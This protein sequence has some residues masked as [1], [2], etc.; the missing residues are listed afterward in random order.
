MSVSAPVGRL[1]DAPWPG[2]FLLKESARLPSKTKIIRESLDA[3]RPFA[4]PYRNSVT[5]QPASINISKTTSFRNVA[6]NFWNVAAAIVWTIALVVL[7][8]RPLLLSQ[9]GTSFDTYGLAGSHWLHGEDLYTH[10]MGFVYS[11]LVAAFFAP[12]AFFPSAIANIVWRLISTAAL[13]GGLTA[14][15]RSNLFPGIKSQRIGIAYLLLAP[16]ALGNIDISQ[17]NPLVA[18]LIMLAIAAVYTERWNSAALY[19]GIAAFFKIYPLAVGLLIC[20]IAPRRFT[21]RLLSALVLLTLAPF[22]F[23]HWSY[24]SHQ[25]GTWIATRMAEDRRNWPAEKLPLDLWF[26]LHSVLHLPIPQWIFTFIQLGS[27]ATVAVFCAFGSIKNWGPQR[28][29][30]GLFCLS[31]VWMTLCGPATESYTYMLLAAPTLLALLQSMHSR[32]VFAIWVWASVALQLFAVTRA[33]FMP[34]FKPYWILSALP[35]SA[36]LFL[37]YCLIWLP[38]EGC[39]PVWSRTTPNKFSS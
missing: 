24:V 33:S 8:A 27:A 9:R 18:G 14:L 1:T 38:D 17:A 29:L 34:H 36:L 26:V 13:L 39:W 12:F 21:W 28:V 25:Y 19:I 2:L 32:Q 10:W 16:L 31:A 7:A 35:V 4:P 5:S 3:K 30:T 6:S 15:F 11:P 22:L 23:Q 20:V 37:I